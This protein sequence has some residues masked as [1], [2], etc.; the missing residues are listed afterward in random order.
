MANA[1]AKK[2]AIANNKILDNLRIGF[3]V[4]HLLF[5]GYRIIY[6]WPTFTTAQLAL[7]IL[8]TGVSMFMY[9]TLETTG[10]PY[11]DATG[12]L[13]KS[14]DDMNAEGL[15][16]YMFDIIYVTWFTQIM[17][18]FVSTKF[19]YTFLVIPGYASY[20]LFP[21][22]L[23]YIRQN[24]SGGEGSA[25]GAEGSKSKRQAKMEKRSNKGNVK[26]VR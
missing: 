14:G 23:S 26:Y 10:R 21:M 22:I 17:V 2:L 4:V 24:R 25:K 9:S 12:T 16:A 8:T 1:S 13:I 5:I 3:M 18:A 6:N 20:K 19:W 11:Y 7:Y 15:T